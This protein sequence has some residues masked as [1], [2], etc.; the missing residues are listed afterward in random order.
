MK[1]TNYSSPFLCSA[2]DTI[3]LRNQ[4]PLSGLFGLMSSFTPCRPPKKIL[5]DTVKQI[6]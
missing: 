1:S 6:T 5:K 2:S 3:G 4:S